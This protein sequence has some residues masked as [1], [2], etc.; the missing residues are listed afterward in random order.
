MRPNASQ[1]NERN[2]ENDEK[3]SECTNHDDGET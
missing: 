2:A 3:T 1:K